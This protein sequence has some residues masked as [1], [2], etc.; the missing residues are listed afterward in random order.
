MTDKADILSIHCKMN[1]KGPRCMRNAYVAEQNSVG[2]HRASI[3]YGRYPTTAVRVT[4]H[5]TSSIV[6][7]GHYLPTAVS[8]PPQFLP[9]ANTP[10]YVLCKELCVNIE[11]MRPYFYIYIYISL[12]YHKWGWQ[13]SQICH[14]LGL[15]TII[16]LLFKLLVLFHPG[17]TSSLPGS[18][19]LFTWDDGPPISTK[20]NFF[21]SLQ[22][23][24]ASVF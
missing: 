10:Q 24:L 23:E 13:A 22:N 7:V 20:L 16:E 18:P 19:W 2:R 4:Y 15:L 1:L 12:Y 17:P 11:F 9:W 5:S 6:A 21:C 8:L 3:G 14:P